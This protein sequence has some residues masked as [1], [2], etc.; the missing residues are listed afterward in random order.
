[1]NLDYIKSP[2]FYTNT[3]GK[4]L[5]IRHGKTLFNQVETE[6]NKFIVKVDK[7]YLD[8]PLA[9]VGISQAK[10]IQSI[11]NTFDIEEIYVSPLTRAL[12]TASYIFENHPQ[13]ENITIKVHPLITETVNGVHD[14]TYDITERKNKFNLNTHPVKFDWCYFDQKFPSKQEQ[15]LNFLTYIDYFNEK[16][17]KEAF[18]RVYDVYNKGNIE[19][20]KQSVADLSKYAVDAGF[21][22]CE[23]LKSMLNR[24]LA[25][26]TFLKV[27]H[28]ETLN[29][30]NRKVI[31]IMHSSFGKI[32]TSEKALNM[33][34]INDFPDDCYMMKNCEIISKNI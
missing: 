29:N 34:E 28:K 16:Q 22:R 15:D 18:G 23:K 5:Y 14:F 10:S 11:V 13:R 7:N 3:T 24:G 4:F 17:K 25:F 21:P 9:D 12:Q 27:K 20:L 26:E 33:E 1:M 32:C 31:V 6:E 19:E 2:L 8:S 30:T